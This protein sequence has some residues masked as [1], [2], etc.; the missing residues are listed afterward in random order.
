MQLIINNNPSSYQQLHFREY[1]KKSACANILC[2]IAFE[3]FI[4]FTAN[5]PCDEILLQNSLWFSYY[6]IFLYFPL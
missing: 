3:F 6:N 4:L 5:C 2:M 1:F